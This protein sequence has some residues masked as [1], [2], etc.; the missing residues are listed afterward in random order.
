MFRF[1]VLI[2]TSFAVM[3]SEEPVD[4]SSG[5][6]VGIYP[7]PVKIRLSVAKR[8]SPATAPSCHLRNVSGLSF[9]RLAENPLQIFPITVTFELRV[10]PVR[11]AA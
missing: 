7:L 2:T 3:S 9:V 4:G 6:I 5:V 1:P 10:P 11:S 8:W